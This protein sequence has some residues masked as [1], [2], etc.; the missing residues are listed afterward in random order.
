MRAA[1][2]TLLLSSLFAASVGASYPDFCVS[3]AKGYV[4]AL[5][6]PCPAGTTAL[7]HA[8]VNLFDV[9]WGAWGTG[10]PNATLQTSL[11]AIRDAAAS[12]YRVART[13]AS[14]W[15]YT[16]WAWMDPTTREAYWAAAAALI[17]EAEA[18]QIK[19]IPSLWHGCPDT[20][21]PCNPAQA[22]YNETYREFITNATSL[23][24]LAL[25]AY[26]QDFVARFKHS[27]AILMW[28]L[29]NEMNLF[30]D[31]C[32]YDKSAGAFITTAEG[33]AWQ[34]D[35]TA[36]IKAVDPER[37]VNS[38]MSV[39]RSRAKHLMNTPGG[40]AACVTPANPQGDC[41]AACT[42]V[43]AD[44]QADFVDMLTLYSAG[45][46][47][48]TA[49]Y[50]GCA[51]PYGNLSWCDDPASTA[52]LQ[53]L[54]DTATALQKPLYVGEFG[55]FN[56][57]WSGGD[58]AGRALLVGMAGQGVALST[59]W[60]FE[61]PSHDHTD[62]PG[63]CLHPGQVSAQPYSFEVSEIAQS[64]QRQLSGQPPREF[65]MSLHMLPPPAAP[66]D[67]S[68]LDGSAYGYYVL[69][70]KVADKWIVQINGGGWCF[71]LDDCFARTQPAYA[72]GGLGS[73]KY[74]AA[75]S[76]AFDFGPD[77]A[78]WGALYLPYCDGGGFAGAVEQPV[79]YNAS[80]NLF[81][82]GAANM[83]AALADFQARFA[84]AAPA[85][86]VVTGGSAGGLSTTLHVD[87]IGAA[88]G[89]Q[90]IVGVPQCGW[91]PF[92]ESACAGPTI[93]TSN[94]CNATGDF[95]ALVE[96][97]N[98][99]GALSAECRAAQRSGEEWR[100]FMAAVATPFVRAPLFVWQSK[101]DHF[102]LSAF[103]CVDCS[104]AQQY[105]PP[106]APAPVCSPNNTRDILAYGAYFMEQLQ[107]LI[108]APGPQRALYL[109]SCV[110]H[111]MDYNFLTVG[112]NDAGELGVTPSVAFNL[113]YTAIREPASATL[114]NN[115]KWVEDLDM[116]RVDNPLACPPFEFS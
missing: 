91:F 89:A 59:L 23:T 116:P 42:T 61:C 112:A 65:N 84:V 92:W 35:A 25:K 41:A 37:P 14:P 47:V 19:L 87:A 52:P 80:L 27:P 85:E 51:A 8:G 34:R 1:T 102:Q 82:R 40:G 107:P 74:W 86:V 46:E 15:G 6:N 5:A 58:S 114:T 88:L 90:A 28:E 97:Q 76:W 38:G 13:F 64:V 75:W 101:F 48:L 43:P 72:G 105:N 99:T 71:G 24:R 10:G 33:L 83:R 26:H 77:F 95:R 55:P 81:F 54:V 12:G 31:G 73:S 69:P 100:C 18:R 63:F 30:F 103:L 39:P 7:R 70:G 96:Q 29:G 32:S 68:C 109:T 57:N 62:Q 9:F 108:D 78:D 111:G 4:V 11:A 2:P 16:D 93:T 79:P 49:H 50:Y 110:L 67:P 22:L 60:A 56:G 21:S 115:Y 36:Y 20:G 98:A 66:G 104:Y 45:Q 53:V 106:W 44:S 17:A 94:M 3:D 113:W